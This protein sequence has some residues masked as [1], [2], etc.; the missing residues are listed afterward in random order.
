ME[1]HQNIKLLLQKINFQITVE[2]CGEKSLK[3]CAVDICY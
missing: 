1:E 3:Y 2:K